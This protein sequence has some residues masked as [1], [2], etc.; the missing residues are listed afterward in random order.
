MT[1][2]PQG[3]VKDTFPPKKSVPWIRTPAAEGAGHPLRLK[4][5]LDR[6]DALSKE[7]APANPSRRAQGEGPLKIPLP[8]RRHPLVF[9]S[10]EPA[11]NRRQAARLASRFERINGVKTLT[12]SERRAP[13][14]SGPAIAGSGLNDPQES[15]L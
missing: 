15:T 13:P 2:R 7:L 4:N 11:L 8:H 1:V 3:P 10:D 12:F 9:E 6:P 5:V 14:C